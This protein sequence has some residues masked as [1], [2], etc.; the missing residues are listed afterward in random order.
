MHCLEDSNHLKHQY[1]SNLSKHSRDPEDCEDLTHSD[2]CSGQLH[3]SGAVCNGEDAA[4]NRS[5]MKL[6]T[7]S[8]LCQMNLI[9]DA[10]NSKILYYCMMLSRFS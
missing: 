5:M 8:V 1:H 4:L 3:P 9:S 6:I 10:V 2:R 7:S